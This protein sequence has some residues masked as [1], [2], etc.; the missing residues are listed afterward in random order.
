[1]PWIPTMRP[2]ACATC[3]LLCLTLAACQTITPEEQ[4]ALDEQECRSY[5]FRPNTDAFAEC[6]QRIELDRRA[7][8]RYQMLELD[9][10][11]EP[12]IVYRPIIVHHRD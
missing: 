1:M 12:V 2:P 10:W 3:L 11:E 5:G 6:L 8:R 9:R 4:R 7:Q